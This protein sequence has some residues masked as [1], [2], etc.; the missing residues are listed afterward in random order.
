MSYAIERRARTGLRRWNPG[1]P[2]GDP[3]ALSAFAPISTDLYLPAL[4]DA[5]DDLGTSASGI[6]ITLVVSMIG[7]GLGNSSWGRLGPIRPAGPLLAGTAVF[8]VASLLC[9]LAPDICSAG[10]VSVPAGA[11]RSAGV[12][13]GRAI[14]RDR[15]A[16]HRLVEL[17][18]V[19]TVVVSLA[20]IIAPL[21]GSAILLVGSWRTIFAALV[22]IG[23][24][25]AIA[26]MLWVPETLAPEHR[27]IGGCCQG[28]PF[29]PDTAARSSVHRGDPDLGRCL[30]CTVRLHHR[31]P[32]RVADPSRSVTADVLD[33]LRNQRAVSDGRCALDSG[34]RPGL[35]IA[36]VPGSSLWLAQRCC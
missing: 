18:G 23:V 11:R 13:I 15:V 26:T 3:G 6:Q 27:G 2:A 35:R 29:L 5:A 20:P 7:L 17:F 14:V 10:G 33:R 21:L 8:T 36:V 19:L 25:L 30:R 12:V 22:V 32:V 34:G 28:V 9:V 31:L 1:S 16:G 24:L 4:P